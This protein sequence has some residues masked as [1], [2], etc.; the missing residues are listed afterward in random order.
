MGAQDTGARR[1]DL[2]HRAEM[3]GFHWGRERLLNP[4]TSAVV[5]RTEL[6][7]CWY[8][9]ALAPLGRKLPDPSLP[10]GKRAEFLQV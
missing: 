4:D 9:N 10:R 7:V 1:H 8:V 2:A 3:P 6:V 5:D